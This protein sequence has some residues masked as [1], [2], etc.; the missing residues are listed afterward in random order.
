M[1]ADGS[2][3]GLGKGLMKGHVLGTAGLYSRAHL[4]WDGHH[5]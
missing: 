4:H 3:C 1:V 2:A 5:F